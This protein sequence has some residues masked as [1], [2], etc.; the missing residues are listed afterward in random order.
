MGFKASIKRVA[1]TALGAGAGYLS[2]GIPGAVAG[3]Y[4]A[5]NANGIDKDQVTSIAR[6]AG[7]RIGIPG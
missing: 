1:A 5:W 2:G 3:G 6:Y 4:S 7:R